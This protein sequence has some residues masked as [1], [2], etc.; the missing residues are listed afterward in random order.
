MPVENQSLQEKIAHLENKDELSF[1]GRPG[2]VKLIKEHLGFYP[3]SNSEASRITT[4]IGREDRETPA[5]WH[6]NEVSMHQYKYK[7]GARETVESLV[8]QFEEFAGNAVNESYYME[9]LLDRLSVIDP[10]GRTGF[11][12]LFPV[13]DWQYD[14]SQIA[15]FSAMS[16]YI[17]TDHFA[18]TEENDR[19]G[20][21]KLI[22]H[23]PID[24][25]IERIRENLSHIRASSLRKTALSLRK[26]QDTRLN[27]WKTQL[28]DSRRHL[29]AR[30]AAS[31]AL[32][33]L[34][35]IEQ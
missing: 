6:L 25:R 30:D 13:E 31:I 35:S 14:N 10:N 20:K 15:V 9:Q 27:F 17:E 2:R 32:D 22:D 33:E 34:A 8:R 21:L 29:F 26:N 7:S 4:L 5:F 28:E 16:R 11:E 12:T 24:E 18:E 3:Q 23:V 1:L 19:L